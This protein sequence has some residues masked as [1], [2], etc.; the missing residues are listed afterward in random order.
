MD[1]VDEGD[2][3]VIEPHHCDDTEELLA[4]G[5]VLSEG[6]D[7]LIQVIDQLLHSLIVDLEG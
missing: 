3:A 5:V 6:K 2:F 7:S 4:Q 1:V